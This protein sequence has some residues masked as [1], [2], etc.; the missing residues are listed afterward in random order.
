[1]TAHQF[2]G[3]SREARGSPTSSQLTLTGFGRWPRYVAMDR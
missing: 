2:I 1:V 3:E